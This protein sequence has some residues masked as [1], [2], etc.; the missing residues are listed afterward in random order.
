MA[1]LLF[2][3]VAAPAPAQTATEPAAGRAAFTIFVRG[4]QIGREDVDLSRSP[5]GWTISSTNR[6]SPPID[7]T[8]NRFELRYGSDWQPIELKLDATLRGAPVGL[9]TSFGVTTAISEITQA[10][11]TTQKTDEIKA[12]TVV[13]PNN[14][15]G[16]YEALAARLAT[17]KTGDELPAYIAPQVEIPIRI[18]EIAAETIRT[19]DRLVAVRRVQLTFQNPGGALQAAIWIDDRARLARFEIPSISLQVVREDLAS[20]AARRETTS[21]PGDLLASIPASGFTLAA[22]IT[23]PPGPAAAS[24]LRLPAVIL[25]GGSGQTDRDEI[26]AGIPVFGQLAGALA[27]AGFIVVRYDKRGVGQ[28]G[29]RLESATLV[30]FAEDVRAVVKYLSKREDVDK[31]RIALIGF[32]EGGAVAMLAASREKSIGA[33]ALV[34]TTGSL[35]ADLILEQQRHVLERLKTPDA[36]K[37]AKIELQKKIQQAV[38]TGAGWEEIPPEL[39]KQ[40]DTPWFQSLLAFD[41]AKVMPKVSQP[42]LVVQGSLDTQVPPHHATRLGELANARKKAPP[43]DVVVVDG[44]NHLLVPATTGEVDEYAQLKERVVS[45]KVTEK[46]VSWLKTVM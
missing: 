33:V 13:L 11:Q 23:R 44:V 30:D 2:L 39:R 12:R 29:G 19:P 3:A 38:L 20:V 22:T 24:R 10:G 41:P 36:E 16:A 32:S 31:R 40:A 8:T 46:I 21:H 25:V 43:T 17:A 27:D 14:H 28:S 45:P 26:V 18:G 4:A 34:A 7:L 9:V 15:F 35:G 6:L 5:G 37:Q 42:V 1:A